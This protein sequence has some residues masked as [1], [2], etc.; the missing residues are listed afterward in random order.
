MDASDPRHGTYAGFH[1][2]AK[3]GEKPCEPCRV[4]QRRYFKGLKFRLDHGHRERVVLGEDAWNIIHSMTRAALSQRTGINASYLSR[5]HSGGHYQKVYQRTR[6]KVL[7]AGNG[8]TP[9]GI[10][11]RVR[12]LYALGYSWHTIE[13]ESGIHREAISAI[14]QGEPPKFVRSYV[15]E[16][17]VATYDRLHMSLPAPSRS[18]TMVRNAAR[19]KG[20][21]PPLAYDEGEIDRSEE[22]FHTDILSDKGFDEAVI[23]RVLDGENMPT[24]R[25]E[26]VEIMRRWLAAGGSERAL[27]IRMGWKT[28]RYV[29]TS[30]Q[31]DRTDR[32]AS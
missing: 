19:R 11:R 4:A 21:L 31:P 28:G 25:A 1:A 2:H 8:P 14:A 22:H 24:T 10:Q 6:A 12:A 27:C 5:L 26:K 18:V 30:A 7:A 15:V 20:W 29:G 13:R 32:K 17:L 9:V 16:A 23:L 3:A